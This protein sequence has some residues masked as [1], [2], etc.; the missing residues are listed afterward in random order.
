MKR[1][2]KHLYKLMLALMLIATTGS[3]KAQETSGELRGTIRDEKKETVIGATLQAVHVPSGTKYSTAS[4]V[5]GRFVLPGLRAGG[6]YRLTISSI[7]YTTRI[8]DDLN[9]RLGAG[10]P[11]DVVLNS[12][13]KQ[14]SEVVIKAAPGAAR[15]NNYGAGTNISREQIRVQPSI[16]RSLQ[17]LT[18]LSPLSTKD[19]SFA[20]TN[21]RYNN[22]TIDGAVNNDAIGFSP[23]A[24]GITGTS[25]TP[26]SSTRANVISLDAIQDV[27]VYVAPYDVK[28]GNFSGGSVNAVTRSGTN[29]VEGSVYTFGRNSTITGN[30]KLGGNG[31]LP[32]SFHDYQIGG[33]L[34]FPIVKDKLFFFLN[35]EYANRVDPIQNAAGTAASNGILSL[36]DAQKIT[37]FLQH[38]GSQPGDNPSRAAFDPGTYDNTSIYAKSTKVFSRADWNISDKHQL[39]LRNNT[40]TSEATNLE[41]DQFDFKFGGISYRENNNQSS[42]VAELKS[43]FSSKWNNSLIAGFTYNHDYRTPSSNPEFP[44]VQIQ[45]LTPGTTIFLGTDR[46]ASLF[47]LTQKTWEFTD[48]LTWYKGKHTVTIGTHNELY[49][50]DY[51]F[52]NSPNGRVD[53]QSGVNGTTF[54]GIDAFL[55]SQPTRVRGNYNYNDNSRDYLLNNPSAQFRINLYSLYIQDE[56]QINDRLKLTPGLRADM[57]DV[58]QKQNLSLKTQNAVTDNAL[59]SQYSDYGYTP[60]AKITNNYFGTP[61]LS[62]RLGINWDVKGDRSLVMR[63]GIGMFVSRI[64][65]AWLGYAFYNNGDTFGAYDA[66]AQNTA[67]NPNYSPL[68]AGNQGIASFAAGNGQLVNNPQSGQTQVDLID[69]HFKM[70]KSLRTS[71]AVDYKTQNG[72]KFTVE[73]MYTKVIKDVLFQQINQK[74]AVGYYTYDTV[75]RKQPIFSGA[76][77]DPRFTNIYLLSNTSK[78]YKYN[79]T[80]QASKTYDIG[81]NWSAAYTYGQAKD[82]SNGIRNSLESNWQLNQALNPNNPDL[83]YSNFDIRHRIISNLGYAK[84]Y[85]SGSTAVSVFVSI[86][87][88]SPFTYGFVNTSIQNTGQQ[89]SLAY[90]PNVNEAVYFFKDYTDNG[91]AVH[92]ATQQAQA[93]NQYIDGDSY[94]SSRRGNFTERNGGRTPWNYQADLRFI[95]NFNIKVHGKTQVVTLTADILNF[96]N[97]LNK[98]W[99][100]Q[101][102]SPNTF[103][104]T[105][106]IGL[107][108]SLNGQNKIQTQN[109]YP[110]YTFTNP[111][112]PYS[113]DYFSSR[114][115]GQLGLRYSF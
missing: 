11:L 108:P 85:K 84:S 92:T 106:S 74:D 76:A 65:F 36:Q 112:T 103:N 61:Q 68:T 29:Q 57:A 86:Q 3:V 41:R 48:N 94:L 100:V 23:S 78:G 14:L 73:G 17:D 50:I 33:R 77:T 18:K 47:N 26:G 19:N 104:S 89:V 16:S 81:F 24:G 70:P 79:L 28:L 32:N 2:K 99:G 55:N 53:Y 72:Y 62:P 109:G 59:Y 75:S 15:A 101:Y 63:G 30:D 8:I 95:Q 39:S 51:N 45:G 49:N 66:K 67:F 34:G 22:I 97:A 21:F 1:Y 56:I 69:N 20:G 54:S 60:A 90:I 102:F 91:G 110:V 9:V 5:N 27:Q 82:V 13:S 93:F 31:K 107:L 44:Q 80:F 111:G 52:V 83:A 38:P 64:P 88:G 35:G 4:D 6:P 71:L 58:P 43:H 46:E 114:V 37:Y 25:G 12:N 7:G 10:D 98:N 113:I 96:T 105:A 42:T 115:Q 87:S 40:I